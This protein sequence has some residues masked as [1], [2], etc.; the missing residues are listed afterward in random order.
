MSLK[1][2]IIIEGII[3]LKTGLH[4]G[5][6]KGIIKI[7]EI[8]NNV[9]KTATGVPY[10]PGSSLKGKLRSIAEQKADFKSSE[11]DNRTGI[12]NSSKHSIG[13]VFGVG[14]SENSKPTLFVVR[15]CF[16]TDEF[17]N[18]L[19]NREEVFKNLEKDLEYTISKHENVIN[20]KTG[21]TQRGGLREIERIPAG[22]EFDFNM[23]FNIWYDSNF[24][25]KDDFEKNFRELHTAMKMLEDDYLGGN[26]S[27]GYGQI[28]FK[29]I[30]ISLK[31]I[32]F[33]ESDNVE[34]IPIIESDNI[35]FKFPYDDIYKYF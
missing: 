10:I 12:C 6:S 13:R 21:G 16:M 35:G 14:A 18:K 33:Y 31:T 15:D 25:D 22:V 9:I 8:D 5:G 27:R 32:D 34:P 7:G 20:R 17:K 2:K 1:G 28:K 29:K 23:V 19:I 24:F 11:V 30:K 3:E 26:G 4:I